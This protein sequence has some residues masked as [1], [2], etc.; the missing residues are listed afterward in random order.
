MCG[1]IGLAAKRW[2]AD[3]VGMAVTVLRR[4]GARRVVLVAYPEAQV[5]DVVGPLEVFGAAGFCLAGRG[6]G[7]ER[8]AYAIEIVAPKAGVLRTQSGIRLVADRSFAAVR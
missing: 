8:D 5:L 4:A 3:L 6:R 7:S 2:M 1:D